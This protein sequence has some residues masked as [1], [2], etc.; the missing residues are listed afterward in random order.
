MTN[1]KKI[2]QLKSKGYNLTFDEVEWLHVAERG[3]VKWKF[4]SISSMYNFLKALH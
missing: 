2:N 3:F 1:E 4:S